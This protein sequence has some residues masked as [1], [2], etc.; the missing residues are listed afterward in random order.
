MDAKAGP[1][2]CENRYVGQRDGASQTR[3][4]AESQSAADSQP[5]PLSARD[6]SNRK[7]RSHAIVGQIAWRRSVGVQTPANEDSGMTANFVHHALLGIF[8]FLMFWIFAG[9]VCGAFWLHDLW[10]RRK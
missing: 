3:L 2:Y 7:T 10:L 1:A 9:I 8:D 4:L 6:A 5:A